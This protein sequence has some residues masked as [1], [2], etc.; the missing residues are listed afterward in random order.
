LGGVDPQVV[1][2]YIHE[3]RRAD[4]ELKFTAARSPETHPQ[5]IDMQGGAEAWLKP[6]AG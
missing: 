4:G 3:P 2:F 5:S 1:F 6:R